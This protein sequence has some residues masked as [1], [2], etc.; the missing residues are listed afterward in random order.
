MNNVELS[1]TTKKNSSNKKG[2]YQVVILK[3]Y[4]NEIDIVLDALQNI[5]G[6]NYIQA[7]SCITIAHNAGRCSVFVDSYEECD[8][9]LR[10]F[11]ALNIK[12]EIQKYKPI[13]ND[14]GNKKSNN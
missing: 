4:I 10:E 11:L 6:H 14:N 3:D 13:S 2:K 12:T 7:G 1:V 9:V 8:E 5:C